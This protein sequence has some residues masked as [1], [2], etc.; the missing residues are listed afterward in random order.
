MLEGHGQFGAVW[1]S[2]TKLKGSVFRDHGVAQED[3]FALWAGHL[4]DSLAALSDLPTGWH[5]GRSGVVGSG[6]GLELDG[7]SGGLGQGSGCEGE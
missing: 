2:L 6:V 5:A 1:A 3:G 7:G 4:D